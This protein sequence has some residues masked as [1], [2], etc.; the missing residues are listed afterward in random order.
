M[1]CFGFSCVAFGF[2]CVALLGAFGCSG[3][4]APAEVVESLVCGANGT[5]YTVEEADAAG[6]AIVHRGRCDD[7]M[8]CG[9]TADCFAGDLCDPDVCIP[10]PNDCLCVGVFEPVCGADGRDYI[11]VCEA[12]CAEIEVVFEGM[13]K[14]DPCALIDCAPGY[15]CEAGECVPVEPCVCPTVYD[16]VC[17]SD[18]MT[19]G[20]ACEAACAGVDIVDEGVCDDCQ[21]DGDCAPD[22]ICI[23]WPEGEAAYCVWVGCDDDSQCRPGERCVIDDICRAPA[24]VGPC[25]AAFPRWFFSTATEQC[26]PFLWGGCG[27]NPNNFETREACETECGRAVIDKLSIA[28]RAGHCEPDI[29]CPEDVFAPEVYA[30]VCGI[31]G[32][33]YGNPCH[34]EREGVDIAYDGECVP[35]VTCVEQGCP[36]GWTCDH[37]QTSR[38][39]QYIC[40]SPFAGACLP[41]DDL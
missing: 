19:Y 18:G 7:P 38:G 27:G 22:E 15:V 33:T 8:N 41:S 12:R 24:A 29:F 11:N 25:D 39:A 10:Q 17:G 6:L 32:K 28:P 5:T 13:C 4:E 26:E 14:D 3:S 9:S 40:L 20:N 31:D 30:P 2:A 36:D 1:K 21:D 23:D 37:C 34:A 35:P 16:P